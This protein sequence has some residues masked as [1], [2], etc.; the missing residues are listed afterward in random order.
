MELQILHVPR[1]IVQKRQKPR[2]VRL[3]IM[4]IRVVLDS[5]VHHV[6]RLIQVIHHRIMAQ[7]I[8]IIAMHVRPKQ[9][10]NLYI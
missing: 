2:L 1:R 10:R 9:A 8:A 4:G 6:V 5:L 3:D 7:Q